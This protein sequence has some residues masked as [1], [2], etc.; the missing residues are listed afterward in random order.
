MTMEKSQKKNFSGTRA[1]SVSSTKKVGFAWGK[2]QLLPSNTDAEIPSQGD[3]KVLMLTPSGEC[4]PISTQNGF[5][6]IIFYVPEGQKKED[7]PDL[8]ENAMGKSLETLHK[9]DPSTCLL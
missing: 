1:K 2:E 4:I 9:M 7:I 3:P 8:W 5:E 6:D